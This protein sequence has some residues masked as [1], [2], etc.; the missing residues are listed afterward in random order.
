MI[1]FFLY[2]RIVHACARLLNGSGEVECEFRA[3]KV[4]VR[5]NA[6]RLMRIHRA[7]P[8]REKK[9]KKAYQPINV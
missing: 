4:R 1:F 5:C 7:G 9:S 3:N 8:D 2:T 6:P